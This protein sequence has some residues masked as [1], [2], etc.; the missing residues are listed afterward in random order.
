MG[1]ALYL[2]PPIIAAAQRYGILDHGDGR[3]KEQRQPVAYLGGLVVFIA[4]LVALAVT[5][6]FD[7]KLLALLLGASLTVSV[8]LVDDLGTLTPKDKFLGQLLAASVLVKGGVVIQLGD[9][10]WYACQAVSILWV[11]SVVNAFNIIDVSDGLCAGVG[12]A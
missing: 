9:W 5:R 11:V 4:L 7:P 1:V 6:T 2:A 8:G 12:A 10:P 3:L